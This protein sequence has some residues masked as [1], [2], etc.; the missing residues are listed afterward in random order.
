M[1]DEG[2]ALVRQLW[3]AGLAHRDIKPANLLVQGRPPAPHRR[4]LRAGAPVAVA[5]GGRPR[6]HDAGPRGAHRRRARVRP[7][8]AATSRPDEIA[9]AFAA[10]R[11]VASPTQLRTVMKQDGRDLVAQFRA[12][13]PA[14]RPISL[15]RWSIRRIVYAVAL[16]V[17]VAARRQSAMLGPA[18]PPARRSRRQR[19]ADVR[20]RRPDDP[21]GA[22]RA[23]RRPRCRA[24][25]SLPAGWELGGVQIRR[26]RGRGSGSTP[27][28]PATT[29]SR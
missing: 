22:V 29:P 27:T 13:A 2:L 1:I 20:H 18:R 21:H 8:A 17:V 11:G 7:G 4:R 3:D 15:Q 23:R 28:A 12:L 26:R 24:S 25:P 9:E 14:R 16:V 5:P 19:H 10:T 6:Q